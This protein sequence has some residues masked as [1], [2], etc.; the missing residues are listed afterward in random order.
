MGRWRYL[1]RKLLAALITLVFVLVLNFFLF[2]ILPGN[3]AKSIARSQKLSQ[4][5]TKKLEA[6]FG[7][8]KSVP[9]Q[10]LI[11]VR[12]TAT[13][14]LGISYTSSRPVMEEIGNRVWNTVLLVGLAT[15]LMTI[16]GL[17][18]GIRGAWRRGSKFDVGSLGGSL[19]LY[20]M[21]EGWLGMMLMI[22]FAVNLG[23]FPVGG[24]ESTA[25]LTGFSHV[26]DV[27]NH[28]ML[29][30]ITLTLGYIGEYAIIMRSSLIEVM[31]EDFITTARAKGLRDKL[32]RRRHAVPNA[33]LPTVTL[34]VLNFGYIFGGA[35]IIEGIFSWPGLGQLTYEAIDALDFPVI[36]AIV[37]LSSAAVI[38]ANLVADVLYTYLD[39][40]VREG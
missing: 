39:P 2:R 16:I 5:D 6:E 25:G 15:I 30:L 35:I 37:L 22:I 33:L 9:Q 4:E 7:L 34:V 23:W 3:P 26:I 27:L 1:L 36:Q 29:P 28:L 24:Y 20:S 14:N 11:Y 32:V 31:N 38:F 12:E 19:V 21:P 18:V 40:R 13:G 10:F 8:D 17:L